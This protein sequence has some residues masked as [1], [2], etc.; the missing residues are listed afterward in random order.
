MYLYFKATI[1][2][3]KLIKTKNF[4]C[5]FI[6]DI[7]LAES[8]VV[9]PL[10]ASKPSHFDELE[11]IQLIPIIIAQL[12]QGHVTANEKNSLEKV[13][14]SALWSLIEE[15]SARKGDDEMNPLLKTIVNSEEVRLAKRDIQAQIGND[16]YKNSLRR[17][18]RGKN[19]KHGVKS[20]RNSPTPYISLD[21]DRKL[22]SPSERLLNMIAAIVHK[23]N[24]MAM[25]KERTAAKMRLKKKQYLRRKAKEGRKNSPLGIAMPRQRYVDRILNL[26]RMKRSIIKFGTDLEDMK[27]LLFDQV[28]HEEDKDEEEEE[29]DSNQHDDN[30]NHDDSNEID[31]HVN[32]D[33]YMDDDDDYDYQQNDVNGNNEQQLTSSESDGFNLDALMSRR[34]NIYDDYEN[35][36]VNEFIHLSRQRDRRERNFEEE[37]Q[38]DV[39]EEYDE[40]DY[41]DEIYDDN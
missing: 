19:P 20:R 40:E 24:A 34:R 18:Y 14:G 17:V 4:H 41:D 2:N 25:E 32:D 36:S 13:F 5:C 16:I 7:P 28:E 31:Q 12:R 3:E 27:A 6:V 11:V 1:K 35:G 29:I 26:N 9:H 10:D 39:D 38:A 37:Y 15:E 8:V 33:D 23:S 21:D 22:L 30:A